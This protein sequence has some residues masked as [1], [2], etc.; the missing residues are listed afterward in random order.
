MATASPSAPVVEG[1][2]AVAPGRRIRG[3]AWVALVVLGMLAY[4]FWTAMTTPGSMSPIHGEETDH[5]NLLSR[6]FQKG[7]LYLDG[8]VPAEIVNAKNPYDPALREKVAVLHD[9]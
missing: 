7:H 9:A 4:Y 8:D 1:T 6:G 3:Q 2:S 5:F